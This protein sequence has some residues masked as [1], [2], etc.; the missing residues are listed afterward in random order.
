MIIDAIKGCSPGQTA[1]IKLV[2]EISLNAWPSHKMEL[3]DGW[4]IRFSHNYTHRTN[5]V[6]QVGASLVPINEKIAYCEQIYKNYHT[7]SIFKI[8][9]LL[10]PAFDRILE[11]RGY[12]IQHVTDTMTMDFENLVPYEPTHIEYEYYGRNSGLPS[13]ITYPDDVIVNL[14]DRIT[15]EWV[16]GLFR[17]NGTTSPTLRRI[18]PSMYQAI[19]KETIAAS[20]KIN[21]T[22]VACG[23]GIL[24]RGYVGVY[25]VYV[26]AGCRRRG[27]AR[28]IVSAILSEGRKKGCSKAY[29]QCVQGNQPAR[30]LYESMGF[31]TLYTYWFRARDLQDL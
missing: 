5:S 11:D 4:L 24:D 1:C 27:F 31:Q 25:A 12:Q 7:P 8:S 13:I 29:L 14:R 6:Q 18:V 17:L 28:A 30:K 23:L 9:P 15:D 26:D 10:D 21:G 19:P 3:Y 22:M 16:S 2:E 20:V